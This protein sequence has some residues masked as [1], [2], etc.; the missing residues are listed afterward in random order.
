MKKII[1]GAAALMLLTA[2]SYAAEDIV[3]TLDSVNS[4]I[5]DTQAKIEA[6]KANYKAKQE[7][8]K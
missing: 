6:K 4:K 8:K 7:A 1:L 3:S 2:N 5:V